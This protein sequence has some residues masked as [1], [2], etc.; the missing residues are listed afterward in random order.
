[1]FIENHNGGLTYARQVASYPLLICSKTK[2]ELNKFIDFIIVDHGYRSVIGIPY[3]ID[4]NRLERRVLEDI[5][6]ITKLKASRIIANRPF[7]SFE[8]F[9]S[10]LNDDNL[11]K[12]LEK[13][14]SF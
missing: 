8:E 9:K 12:I 3:P 10:I 2:L 11:A 4:I 6:G 13:H 7:K 14:I 5:P 1:C